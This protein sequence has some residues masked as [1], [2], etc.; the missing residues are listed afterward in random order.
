MTRDPLYQQIL[1]ALGGDL[2]EDL[3]EA[4]AADLLRESCPSL[5]PMTGGDDAGYD[6]AIGTS[7]GPFPLLL[8]D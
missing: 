2:D 6:G 5:A 7:A 4:C 3:F 1:Q 8:H